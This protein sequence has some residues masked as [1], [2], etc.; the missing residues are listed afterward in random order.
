[1]KGVLKMDITTILQAINTVGC[2]ITVCGVLLWQN[3][4]Q[5]ERYDKQLYELQTVINNNTNVLIELS[6]KIDREREVKNVG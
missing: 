6:T 2:P 1:M 5:N 3:M 4:K